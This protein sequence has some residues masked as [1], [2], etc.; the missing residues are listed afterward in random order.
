MNETLQQQSQKDLCTIKE[1]ETKVT[2]LE[3]EVDR[4]D[5]RKN[6]LKGLLKN[7]HEMHKMNEKI[8]DIESQIKKD[9]QES[10]KVYKSQASF[11]LRILYCMLILVVGISW[12]FVDSYSIT[13][14]GSVVITVIAF[15]HSML[16]NLKKPIFLD[17]EEQLM[18]L[19]KEKNNINEAQDYI[20]EFIES[21]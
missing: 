3:D 20:H 14:L 2:E 11:H 4:Y 21:Q 9:T 16:Q 19:S 8:V 13:I 1:L 7:F 12:E 5:C 15:N 18:E 10:I 6:Y 17:R